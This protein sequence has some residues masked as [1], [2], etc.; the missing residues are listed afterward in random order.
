MEEM[1]KILAEEEEAARTEGQLMQAGRNSASGSLGR[2][3]PLDQPGTASG[4]LRAL[5]RS[6]SLNKPGSP[7]DSQRAFG[8]SSSL[9]KP[10][11][12]SDPARLALRE[13]TIRKMRVCAR[14]V[15]HFCCQ[16]NAGCCK[17]IL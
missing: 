1:T 6:S 13:E 17:H 2:S 3:S 4:P 8:R 16:G 7:S 5:G 10:G 14:D 15:D 9:N 11:M 12:P